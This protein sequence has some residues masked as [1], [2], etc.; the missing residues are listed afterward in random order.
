LSDPGAPLWL[1]RATASLDARVRDQ[2][3][4][5]VL[6][7]LIAQLLAGAEGEDRP[8]RERVRRPSSWAT[9]RRARPPY[10]GSLT[11]RRPRG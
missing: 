5:T 8:A 7:I 10:Q 1:L 4:G 3:R 9:P 11:G 6:F 2:V